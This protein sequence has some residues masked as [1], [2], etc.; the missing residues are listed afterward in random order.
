MGSNQH[1]QLCEGVKAINSRSFHHIHYTVEMKLNH[2]SPPCASLTPAAETERLASVRG[3]ADTRPRIVDQHSAF[4][5]SGQIKHG[6]IGCIVFYVISSIYFVVYFLRFKLYC[7]VIL[8]CGVGAYRLKSSCAFS[9]SEAYTF[10]TEVHCSSSES[11]PV[12]NLN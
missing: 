3:C 12:L 11:E 10:A 6:K 5:V 7:L 1:R 9:E 4:D 2:F 8:T